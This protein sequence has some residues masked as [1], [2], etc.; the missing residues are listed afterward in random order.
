[1]FNN[2]TQILNSTAD[3]GSTISLFKF[4]KS[5]TLKS[6]KKKK[7]YFFLKSKKKKNELLKVSKHLSQMSNADKNSTYHIGVVQRLKQI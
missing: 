6:K 7:K 2:T 5:K 3:I 4:P 1:M